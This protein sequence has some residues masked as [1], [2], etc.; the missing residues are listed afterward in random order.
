MSL[1]W[2]QRCL[3]PGTSV[4]LASV[5]PKG[6]PSCCRGIAIRSTDAM[7]TVTI[8]L[9]VATSGQTIANVASTRRLAV[10]VTHPIEHESVQ[11]KGTTT[12]VRLARDE[13]QAFVESRLLDFA[14]VLA[15]CGLPRKI[16]RSI[17]HWPAFAI[18]M[19]VDQVFDQTP[20]PR[21]GSPMP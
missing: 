12:E 21:A 9:P 18:E 19:R 17:A 6:V 20:G 2:S 15:E 1:S 7:K 11:L 4:L 8:Y 3:A 16:T 5:D 10:S 14:G 13:E